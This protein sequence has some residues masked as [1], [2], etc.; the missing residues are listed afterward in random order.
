MLAMY[1]HCLASG[2]F[3]SLSRSK[4]LILEVD[5]LGVMYLHINNRFVRF[6]S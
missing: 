1:G 2:F 4:W 5:T 6:E 3:L